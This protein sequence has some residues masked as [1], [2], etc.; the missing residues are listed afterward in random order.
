M[1]D[2]V[3]KGGSGSDPPSQR[4]DPE[5][6]RHAL[7]QFTAT[8][9]LYQHI[10]GLFTYTDGVRFLADS[11]GAYWL[12]DLIASWQKR[13]RKNYELSQLQI[14][15]LRV[16]SDRTATAD[17]LIDEGI[18]VYQQLIKF[19]DFPLDYLKLYLEGDVLMLPTE[20]QE[21]D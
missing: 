19:S 21:K 18:P 2:G 11:V 9:N 16:R 20:R 7:S 4:I 17:I 3:Q 8:D 13:A 5:K 6:L 1:P 10:S 12:L 14:W 15:E